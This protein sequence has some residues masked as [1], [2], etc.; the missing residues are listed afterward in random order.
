MF[1][2]FRRSNDNS[3]RRQ[4]KPD[5]ALLQLAE[6]AGQLPKQFV[7]R[8]EDEDSKAFCSKID[9]IGTGFGPK[10]PSP[11]FSSN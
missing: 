2:R 5:R 7:L 6:S 8:P 9:G 3:A 4:D 11:M 10:G 1:A